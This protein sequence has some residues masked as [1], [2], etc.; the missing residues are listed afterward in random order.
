MRHGCLAPRLLVAL[1][2]IAGPMAAPARGAAVHGELLVRFHAGVDPA[3][4]I[5]ARGRADARFGRR[6][7]VP[8]LELLRLDPGVG[9]D[10]ARA[11]LEREAGV[12]YAEPNYV[13][14]LSVT[15]N[16]TF[17]GHLWGLHNTGQ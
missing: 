7:P 2:V 14:K 1:T 11:R 4:R 16:D 6:L 3:G 12:V 17:F 9:A 8:G 15:P 13:R 5:A 10:A